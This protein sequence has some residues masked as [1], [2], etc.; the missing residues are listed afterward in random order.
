M[1]GREEEHRVGDGGYGGRNYSGYRR[2]DWMEG[3]G[4]LSI[5]KV[6]RR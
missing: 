3:I 4:K 2:E 6:G 1:R 5:G